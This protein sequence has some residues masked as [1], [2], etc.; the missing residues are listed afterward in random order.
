MKLR[1][2]TALLL[3]AA[4]LSSFAWAAAP[5]EQYEE[6]KLLLGRGEYR[7]AAD[8]FAS[9]GDYADAANYMIFCHAL[10]TGVRGNYAAAAALMTD[11]SGFASADQYAVY[12]TALQYYQDMRYEQAKPLLEGLY[13]FQQAP[14]LAKQCD[15]AIRKRDYNAAQTALQLGK[16]DEALALFESLGDYQD[17]A[18]QAA[19]VR[20]TLNAGL[21]RAAQEALRKAE[22]T[23]NN[24]NRLEKAYQAALSLAENGEYTL[25]Y[26]AF[27]AL[28]DYQD[29]V[30]KAYTLR[31]A[32]F[33]SMKTV[34]SLLASYRFHGQVGLANLKENL[35]IEPLWDD[36]SAFDASG[37]AQ[38]SKE[39]KKGFINSQ[40]DAVI[41]C[42]WDE[43]IGFTDDGFAYVRDQ[44][45]WGVIDRSGRQVIPVRWLAITP[46]RDH[47][48]TVLWQGENTKLLGLMNDRGEIVSEPK[49]QVLGASDAKGVYAP[50]FTDGLI[51][52]QNVDG[53]WGFLN[54]SGQ[55]IIPAIYAA[56]SDFSDGLAEITLPQ[57]G[58]QIINPQGD[59]VYFVSDQ[60]KADYSRAL[61][62]IENSQWGEAY[63]LLKDM[64]NYRDAAQQAVK[65]RYLAGKETLEAGNYDEAHA[66]FVSLGS[67]EDAAELAN[68]SIYQKGAS[69][70]QAG[71][72]DKAREAFLS[73]KE[74]K[75]A[76]EMAD[77]VIYQKGLALIAAKKYNNAREAFLK[78]QNYK[79]AADMADFAL[80]QK[81]GDLMA[82]KNYASAQEVY[83]KIPGYADAAELAHEC[84]YLQGKAL[85]EKEEYEKAT[86]LFKALG[87]YK[88]AAALAAEADAKTPKNAYTVEAV[89]Y[90]KYTF[91]LGTDGYYESNNK[92]IHNSLA[93]CKVTFTTRTGKIYVDCINYGEARYDY[94]AVSK[95][96][97]SDADTIAFKNS[98]QSSSKVQTVT[99]IV[100]DTQEHCI[101]IRYK[102][103][104]AKNMYNDSLKFKIRFE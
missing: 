44:S 104:N 30:D 77:D 50:V 100:P 6:A 58:W 67:Y 45:L 46:F 31:I 7:Q 23:Q 88:D 74:Y 10:A 94:G 90:Y 96:D 41:P 5:Q 59:V 101:Y 65:A 54:A 56:V 9:I 93:F 25:A 28:G 8:L 17:S 52:V 79:D 91:V 34:G 55:E 63:E 4:M 98:T 40:G 85:M 80:Y 76:A 36:L 82:A 102:K 38:V 57:G 13:D 75:D 3:I 37:M 1:A 71:K 48:C 27:A 53:Q 66:I 97:R 16:L 18:G 92:R 62:L 2:I 24:E 68:Q 70:T 29:S 69:L 103:D 49:W 73:V 35:L 19:Q 43:V 21:G 84:S 22:E 64:G 99:I 26:L 89:P 32:T 11:L 78:V 61:Q 33:A 42:Q 81:A 14:L 60:M 51:K 72:Y 20:S 83:E 87:D 47:L 15:D 95:L 39:G 12:F 86:L